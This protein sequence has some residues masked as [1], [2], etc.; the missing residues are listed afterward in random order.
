MSLIDNAGNVSNVTYAMDVAEAK[1]GN[2]S[3]FDNI[4]DVVTKGIPLTGASIVNSFAN[5]AIDIAN[6]FGA[7][8]Q[9]I[10]MSDYGFSPETLQYYEDHAQGVEAAG[11]IV[12][13]LIPGTIAVK[14]L[15]LAQAGKAGASVQRATNIFA[16]PSKAAVDA[17]K[18]EM[19]STSALFPSLAADKVKAIAYG[20]GDNALQALAFETATYA[21]MKASPLLDA[22]SA[23]EVITN[24]MYGVVIGGGIGGIIDGILINRTI[25]QAL[26]NR[27]IATKSGEMATYLEGMNRHAYNSGDKVAVLLDSLDKLPVNS[28]DELLSAKARNTYNEG[29]NKAKLMLSDLVPDGDASVT[30]A[31]FD[32]FMTMKQQGMP[33]EEIYNYFSRL[34]SVSRVTEMPK[35]VDGDIFYISAAAKSSADPNAPVTLSSLISNTSDPTTINRAYK[36]RPYATTMNIAKA[37]DSV[38]VELA[39]GVVHQVP[40]YRNATEAFEQGADVYIGSGQ[41]G[42]L[43]AYVNPKAPNIVQVPKPGEGRVLSIKE[44]KIYRTTGKLPDGARDLLG[45]PIVL[46]TKTGAMRESATPVVGDFGTPTLNSKGLSFG[47]EVSIQS[48]DAPIT[49]ATSALDANARYVWAEMRGIKAGDVIAPNDIAML[50]QLRREI[51]SF[52]SENKLQYS[53]AVEKYAKKK[54]IKFTDDFEIPHTQEGLD[55]IIKAE[56]DTLIAELL[57]SAD[58]A[59]KHSAEDI[60]RRANVSEEYIENGLVQ[61]KDADLFVPVEQHKSIN[62]VRLQYNLNGVNQQDGNIVRG[63]MDSQLRVQ[64][65]QSALDAQGAKF[66]GSEFYNFKI[67]KTSADANLEGVGSKMF[68]FSNSDYNS[69]GQQ[70][71]RIGK[72]V[73]DLVTRRN[74]ITADTLVNPVNALRNNPAAAA[75]WGAFINVRQSTGESFMFLPKQFAD[76][77]GLSEN[78]VVLSK[79]ITRDKAGNIIGWNKDYVPESG[80]WISA[81]KKLDSRYVG[82]DFYLGKM[83]QKSG[84]LHTFYEIS[85]EVARFE[86]A[87]MAINNQ[88]IAERNGFYEAVGLSRKLEPDTLYAPPIDT[89][90]YPHIA[91][92]RA[93]PGKGMSDDSVA[94]MVAKDAKDLEQKIALIRTDGYEVYTKDQIKE[95]KQAQGDY[96]FSRNFLQTEVN[97]A[98]KRKGILNNVF[99]EVDANKI[100]QNYIDWH[101]KHNVRNVRDHVELVN[102][103][104]FAELKAIGERFTQTETSKAGFSYKDIFKTV[105]NPYMDYVNTALGVSRKEQY[106]LWDM[107]NEKTEAFFSTAFNAMRNAFLGSRQG[108]VS[109]EEA[110]AIGQK[111]GLGNP[112]EKATDAMKA[113]KELNAQLP[114]ERILSKFVAASNS[115]LAT[116]VIRLDAFQSLIN[117]V[118]TPVLLNAETASVRKLISTTLPDGSGRQIPATSKLLYNA[119]NNFFS[120]EGKKVLLPMYKKLG[121]V[122]DKSSDYFSMIED[123]TLPYGKLSDS[124]VLERIESAADKAA[125]LTGSEFSEEFVRFVA[126]DVGRQIFETAGKTGIELS[127]NIMTFVN[128]VHGNYVASQRPIAFQGPIGQAIGLF[129]TYQFN[130]MQQVFRYIGNGEGKTIA[131]LAGMQ[132]TL[133]GVQGLPGFQAINNHII[134]N[135]ANN[136]AHKDAYSTI[137]NFFGKELGDYL[138]YGTLSNWLNAG[139]YSRGDI[140]P[141]NI[142]ILPTNPLDYPAISGSIRFISNILDTG[143]KLI[144]GADVGTSIL[145]GLEHNGL[146]RPLAGLGQL[147]QGFSTTSQGSLISTTRSPI[148]NGLS[149]L[150]DASAAI[151]LLGARPLDE[152]IIMD[153]MYR[154]TLYQAKDSERIKRLGETVKTTMYNGASP[155]EEEV[156][157]FITKYAAAGG[158]VEMFSRKMMEWSMDA[159]AS[160]ANQ[161]YR[162]LRDPKN[163]QLQ[164]MMGGTQIPDFINQRPNMAAPP[165]E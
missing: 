107:A 152:A 132:T 134:A 63:L 40:K 17:A 130:L 90:K 154:R 137:P 32:T 120:D 144:Q 48:L 56:K 148:T 18:L 22:D 13:S 10:S 158:R 34:S 108:V 164:L 110:S 143:K 146:S 87:N 102:S 35:Q 131:I 104:L 81:T 118:S 7:D 25:N 140:N 161:F 85:P 114:P 92:V 64:V 103:Q 53:E 105:E 93:I 150:V 124:K 98:M 165:I 123:L 160:V 97:A 5:T 14:A 71:E 74:A 101:S 126:A 136:P 9:R 129:Q 70:V 157:S 111:Y 36:L 23:S 44:E 147:M 128:R 106:R 116:T 109:L 122:R 50:E 142:T 127:D 88:R 77:A 82:E 121:V 94:V 135:S 145:L 69:L 33:K 83:S 76:E 51:N 8:K 78:T 16:A 20:F 163:Q 54:A 138:L 28:A 30:S 59:T 72:Y 4:G 19:N 55:T 31:M 65:I 80:N 112:Y 156:N 42:K 75:E 26:L 3:I 15:K 24:M 6:V 79:S 41:G 68:S 113:Y 153:A 27:D 45:A 115:I 62:H 73:T 46:N 84:G 95:F 66:F 67:S 89:R 151:R 12:G 52:A 21:T 125:K 2:P 39:N 43:S 57:N 11:L 58:D 119:V 141:R 38:E 60:A 159:N 91:L 37:T 86:R 47:S 117:I 139:L 133:F 99:P 61:K 96:D 1:V 162:N 29:L 155:T 100:T 149:D 49:A